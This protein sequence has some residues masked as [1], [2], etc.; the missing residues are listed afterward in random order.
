M[1]RRDG[2]SEAQTP[3]AQIFHEQSHSSHPSTSASCLL[4]PFE[5]MDKFLSDTVITSLIPA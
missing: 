4:A 1:W 3:R 2:E 5:H